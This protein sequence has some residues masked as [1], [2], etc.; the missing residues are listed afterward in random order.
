[1]EVLAKHVHVTRH[2][3]RRL[4]PP[5]W[6]GHAVRRRHKALLLLLLLLRRPLL[7]R[8]RTCLQSTGCLSCVACGGIQ[9]AA[10]RTSEAI[11]RKPVQGKSNVP[12]KDSF[13]L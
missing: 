10:C 11:Y 7:Q 3:L 5:A 1:M 4:H 9:A 12:A 8:R 13:Y 2:A 6:V